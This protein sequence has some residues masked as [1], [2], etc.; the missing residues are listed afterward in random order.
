MELSRSRKVACIERDDVMNNPN[1]IV[2]ATIHRLIQFS[3]GYSFKSEDEI[4]GYFLADIS[5]A[6]EDRRT[7]Y[8]LIPEHPTAERY[9][10]PDGLRLKSGEGK[11]GRIDIVLKMPSSGRIG[12]ELEYPRGS[13]LKEQERFRSHI[14]ND[15]LK[16]NQEKGLTDRYLLVFLYTD[17]P[18]DISN[19]TEEFESE[20]RDV[21]FALLM[22]KKKSSEGR[23]QNPV[24]KDMQYPQNW[25]SLTH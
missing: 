24:K 11:P 9:T 15:L 5:R 25:L 7:E 13:G 14:S 3:R 10:R 8:E 21:R 20:F 4:R 23:S 22:M 17:P 2:E 1:A 18:F 6:I 12:I 19:L 16:L